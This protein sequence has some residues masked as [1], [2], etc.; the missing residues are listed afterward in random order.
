MQQLL[1]AFSPRDIAQL[2]AGYANLGFG[3]ESGAMSQVRWQSALCPPSD[4]MLSLL[5]PSV[6]LKYLHATSRWS[7]YSPCCLRCHTMSSTG[8][9]AGGAAAAAA[10]S[11]S[12]HGSG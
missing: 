1:P 7:P 8:H 3:A 11:A 9:N 4:V 5:A 12:R 2:L 6:E 10:W